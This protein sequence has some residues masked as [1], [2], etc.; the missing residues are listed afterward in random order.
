MVKLQKWGTQSPDSGGTQIQTPGTPEGDI[1]I[2]DRTGSIDRIKIN[3]DPSDP[4]DPDNIDRTPEGLFYW[5]QIVTGSRVELVSVRTLGDLNYGV[6]NNFWTYSD[7]G[8]IGNPVNVGTVTRKIEAWGL[9]SHFTLG[10][11]GGIQISYL[12]PDPDPVPDPV[13]PGS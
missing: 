4:R 7:F 12:R 2:R 10:P 3:P 5:G 6:L 8:S 13:P 9:K 11:A 1:I